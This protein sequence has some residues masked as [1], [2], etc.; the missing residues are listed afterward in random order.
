MILIFLNLL[1]FVL[2]P[3]TLSLPDS[4]S[5]AIEENSYSATTG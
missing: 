4:V 1:K 5:Y 3:S 2:W